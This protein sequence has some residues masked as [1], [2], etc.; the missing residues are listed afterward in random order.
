MRLLA[1]SNPEASDRGGA[2]RPELAGVVPLLGITGVRVVG[3][4]GRD[5][6]KGEGIEA[7]LPTELHPDLE[8]LP[9]KGGLEGA[10]GLLPGLARRKHLTEGALL[11]RCAD[12]Q[13]A[14]RGA[15]HLVH[16]GQGFAPHPQAPAFL[17]VGPALPGVSAVEQTPALVHVM[18][19]R[20]EV[21]VAGAGLFQAPPELD[22][23]AHVE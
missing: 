17:V 5:E 21:A 13:R 6:A 23:V 18:R 22:G 10:V 11:V 16:L 4:R 19:D 12:A 15:L 2:D 1:V 8:P 3:V 9:R 7:E 14:L 20:Q